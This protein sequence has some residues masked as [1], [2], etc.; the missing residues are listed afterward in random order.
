MSPIITYSKPHTVLWHGKF[1]DGVLSIVTATENPLQV[2]YKLDALDGG[3]DGTAVIT[4]Q[5]PSPA[6]LK[7]AV[8]ELMSQIEKQYLAEI[9]KEK[10]KYVNSGK[11]IC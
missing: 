11:L 4:L 1:L 3:F 6:N 5:D 9:L 2:Y 7:L 10:H 8:D